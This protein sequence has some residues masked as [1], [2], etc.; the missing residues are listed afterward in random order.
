MIIVANPSLDGRAHGPH[1]LRTDV[2]DP[3]GHGRRGLLA[4]AVG[5]VRASLTSG[6]VRLDFVQHALNAV[7]LH[8]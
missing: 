6:E 1:P 2:R 4:F 7:L 3:P 5:G 8:P